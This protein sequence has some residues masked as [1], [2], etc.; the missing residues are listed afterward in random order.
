MNESAGAGI[1]SGQA[2]GKTSDPPI[3]AWKSK[4]AQEEYHR[5]MENVTDKNFNLSMWRPGLSMLVDL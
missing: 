4:R 3:A 2:S 5:A 1:A